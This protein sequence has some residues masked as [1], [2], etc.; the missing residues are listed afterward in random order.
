MA[1]AGCGKSHSSYGG[2]MNVSFDAASSAATRTAAIDA[3]RTLP[4]VKRVSLSP[5]AASAFVDTGPFFD[6]SWSK[7][8]ADTHARHDAVIQNCLRRQ[9]GVLD[10]IEGG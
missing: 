7:S 8:E 1:L 2:G 6:S 9:P 4:G 5:G 10:V 3:C